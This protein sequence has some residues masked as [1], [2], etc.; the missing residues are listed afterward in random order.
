MFCTL[1]LHIGV[2][3]QL[4]P[5]C[6]GAFIAAALAWYLSWRQTASRRISTLWL[7]RSVL[8][9]ANLLWCVRTAA[10]RVLRTPFESDGGHVANR[11]H[12]E[13]PA[14]VISPPSPSVVSSL[15]FEQVL[16]CTECF[17]QLKH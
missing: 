10:G 3:L 1:S 11:A 2:H 17:P 16:C 13:T 15:K 14:E 4:G 8:W 5:F 6:V 12:T 7:L 9:T